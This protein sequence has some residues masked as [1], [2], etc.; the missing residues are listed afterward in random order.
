MH[1]LWVRISFYARYF[2]WTGQIQSNPPSLIP[3][4]PKY[5]IQI[6]QKKARPKFLGPTKF[7]VHRESVS[8]KRIH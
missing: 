8:F 5:A 6:L 3:L 2:D 7:D 1:T 4:W